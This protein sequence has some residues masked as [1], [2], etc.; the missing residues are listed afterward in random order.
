MSESER[1]DIL[2]YYQMLY[3]QEPEGHQKKMYEAFCDFVEKFNK[4]A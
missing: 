1:R 2:E 4:E 3:E